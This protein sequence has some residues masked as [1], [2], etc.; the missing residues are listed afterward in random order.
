MYGDAFQSYA[1]GRRTTF[2]VPPHSQVVHENTY[3]R[4]PHEFTPEMQREWRLYKDVS[5]Q[6][7]TVRSGY[8]KTCE[9]LGGFEK[10]SEEDHKRMQLICEGTI[11]HHGE[12][13]RASAMLHGHNQSVFLRQKH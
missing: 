8:T 4:H 10:M 12:R 9:T 7:K 11:N 5:T 2:D 13:I 1:A 3:K 6:N